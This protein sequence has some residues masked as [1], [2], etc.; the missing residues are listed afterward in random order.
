MTAIE[1]LPPQTDYDSR[2]GIH[3]PPVGGSIPLTFSIRVFLDPYPGS[4]YQ[5]AIVGS[6]NLQTMN[7]VPGARAPIPALRDEFRRVVLSHW[8]DQIWLYPPVPRPG[9]SYVKCRIALSFVDNAAA[10]QLTVRVLYHP[11]GRGYAD[12]RDRAWH[13]APATARNDMYLAYDRRNG[14]AIDE[15]RTLTSSDGGS[16]SYLQN[17]LAHEFGHYLGL[18]H[19]CLNMAG[20]PPGVFGADAE[21]CIGRT[22]DEMLDVMAVGN[23]VRGWHGQPW[24]A[25]LRRHQYHNNLTWKGSTTRPP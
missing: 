23:I 13:Y 4:T 21:Y 25:R 10:S 2:L 16:S 11:S 24:V 5:F 1:Q 17:T 6:N 19:T 15:H 8:D 7:V 18:P 22:H 20:G 9:L 12:W 3:D 14:F